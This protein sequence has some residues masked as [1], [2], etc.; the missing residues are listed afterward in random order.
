M[1]YMRQRISGGTSSQ[2]E[3][4][5]LDLTDVIQI[6]LGE[7]GNN[8]KRK[9]SQHGMVYFQSDLTKNSEPFYCA[10]SNLCARG[11]LAPKPIRF[12]PTQRMT[13]IFGSHF[14]LTE[15]GV[16]LLNKTHGVACLPI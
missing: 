11:I 15:Y 4:Y 1:S 13:V 10:A 5:D 16:S 8:L 7:V 12:D 6:Y 3:R 2:S 14:R 9:Q